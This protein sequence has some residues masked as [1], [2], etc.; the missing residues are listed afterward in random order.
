MI[1]SPEEIILSDEFATKLEVEPGDPVTLMVPID[2]EPEKPPIHFAV[3]RIR[4]TPVNQCSCCHRLTDSHLEHR[5]FH[6]GV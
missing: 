6:I 1:Q 4:S 5:T 3:S 2:A